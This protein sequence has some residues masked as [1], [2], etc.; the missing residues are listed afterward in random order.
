MADPLTLAAPQP[1]PTGR[2]GAT[3]WLLPAALAVALVMTLAALYQPA[4]T[5]DF[6]TLD[7]LAYVRDN[8]F[9]RGGP[10]LT[11]IAR[12][13]R[14]HEDLWIPL[15]WL[16]YLAD[17][18][19]AGM[20][21]GVFHATNVALHAAAMGLLLLVLWRMTGAL[22]PSALA[23]ALVALHPLRV[24][25]VAW[26]AERKDVL[27]ML[28]LVGALG[29]WLRCVR[30]GRRLWY[31]AAAVC[32]ALS[33]SAKASPVSFP[34]LL[35][36]LDWWPL[37]RLPAGAGCRQAWTRLIAEKVPLLAL[38]AAVAA[39]TLVAQRSDLRSLPV[40]ERIVMPVATPLIYLQRTFWP[41]G[42]GVRYFAGHHGL[43]A[44]QIAGDV[45]GLAVATGVAWCTRR[46]R[47]YLAAGWVWYLVA[48][49]P[50]SGVAATGIQWLAD[51]FTFL[52]H[53]GLGI[54]AAWLAAAAA[55]LG[56]GR[57]LVALAVLVALAA[58]AATSRLQLGTWRDGVA[59]MRRAVALEP[60]S[61]RARAELGHALLDRHDPGAAAPQLKAAL[62]A[63]PELSDARFNLAVALAN[64]GR[65]DESVAAYR[66]LLA[67][68]PSDLMARLNLAELLYQLRRTEE[69]AAEF[70]VAAAQVPGTAEGEFSAGRV[71]DAAART[72]DARV[73]YG[74]AAALPSALPETPSALR[75]LLRAR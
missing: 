70:A 36:A 10:T 60:G 49:F 15:T 26:I 74:A 42:L 73:H 9:V 38:S 22:W 63:D 8:L 65:N 54:A 75:N 27:S 4:V 58:L 72:D 34:L 17:V 19:I 11:D 43:R 64:L 48:L 53:L 47:P 41:A 51:R 68:S 55:R 67:R 61:A 56:R 62:I 69:A 44:D 66:D 18:S 12:A 25:S 21:P 24:E 13:V 37:G 28:L 7:D 6:V 71:L 16:S 14:I 35:L 39:I 30:S 59:L 29:C 3:A 46:A 33:L 1:G 20:N 45:L 2:A 52:P 32:F 31:A 57:R 5:F 40:S 50:V 23:A